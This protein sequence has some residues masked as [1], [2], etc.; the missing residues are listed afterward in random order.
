MTYEPDEATADPP[1]PGKDYEEPI[2][3]VTPGQNTPSGRP[4]ALV[5]TRTKSGEDDGIHIRGES[6]QLH[7]LSYKQLLHAQAIIAHYLDTT[8]RTAG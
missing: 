6:G 2:N 8:T 1:Q 5:R 3:V 7:R 4:V